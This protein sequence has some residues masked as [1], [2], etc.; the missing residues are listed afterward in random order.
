MKHLAR[1]F[2]DFT[3]IGTIKPKLN[4]FD[5]DIDNG[6]GGL[7]NKLSS[8]NGWNSYPDYITKKR[9]NSNNGLRKNWTKEYNDTNSE[10][11]NIY[12]SGGSFSYNYNS[13]DSA[14]INNDIYLPANLYIN[15]IY[16]EGNIWSFC[17]KKDSENI[18]YTSGRYIK[19]REKSLSFNSPS[20]VFEDSLGNNMVDIYYDG[21]KYYATS[22]SSTELRYGDHLRLYESTDSVTW[23]IIFEKTGV[24][25]LYGRVFK[26]G[27]YIIYEKKDTTSGNVGLF[28]TDDFGI[29][30]NNLIATS[31][32]NMSYKNDKDFFIAGGSIY[33][34]ITFVDSIQ[35][36][37]SIGNK[38]VDSLESNGAIPGIFLIVRTKLGSFGEVSV[39][40]VEKSTGIISQLYNKN[41]TVVIGGVIVKKIGEEII[42]SVEIFNGNW[43]DYYLINSKYKYSSED[44][45]YLEFEYDDVLDEYSPK[46]ID[47]SQYNIIEFLVRIDKKSINDSDKTHFG[48]QI[49]NQDG[50]PV[51]AQISTSTYYFIGFLLRNGTFEF[52]YIFSDNSSD[53]QQK[54]TFFTSSTFQ[55]LNGYCCF[56]FHVD[57]RKTQVAFYGEKLD[58]SIN[59]S[60]R[61]NF[62]SEETNQTIQTIL[63]NYKFIKCVFKDADIPVSN[64]SSEVLEFTVKQYNT[65]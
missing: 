58:G 22:R 37:G 28:Y 27:N 45:S 60:D 31:P 50:F 17:W 6:S 18:L 36:N 47:P 44:L 7:N 9:S 19:I 13:E 23:N 63:E 12:Y 4:N 10:F 56:R 14:F 38:L 51:G 39:F 16:K 46:I 42:F 48:M 54:S 11:D 20:I 8:I 32:L 41:F 3:E 25:D 59:Y 49:C 5:I 57:K 65:L 30:E 2:T 26:K 64:S 35:F 53:N 52:G 62:I 29:T 55:E 21:E 15:D 43:T 1:V 24:S 33:N 40:S 61:K 34:N